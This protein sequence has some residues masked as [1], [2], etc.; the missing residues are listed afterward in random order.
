MKLPSAHT[1]VLSCLVLLSAAPLATAADAPAAEPARER[2][3][4]GG[5]SPKERLQ[6][7]AQELNLTA[8]QK[9]KIGAL[10]K[11]QMEQG[12]ALRE[13]TSLSREQKREQMEAMRKASRDQ[14]RALLTAEQQAKFD[15]LPQRGPGGPR[16]ERPR[17]D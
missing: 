10:L 7:L 5:P 2:G 9:E 1:L 6:I 13:D 3:P 4:G 12:R 17:R 15:A 11:Q 14:I 16:G 8:E